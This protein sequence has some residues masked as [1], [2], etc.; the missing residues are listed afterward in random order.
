MQSRHVPYSLQVLALHLDLTHSH[1]HRLHRCWVPSL[2]EG[3][4][5]GLLQCLAAGF[6]AVGEGYHL[7]GPEVISSCSSHWFTLFVA[8]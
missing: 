1:Q 3:E 8:Q 7:V 5:L 4:G 6:A 2:W